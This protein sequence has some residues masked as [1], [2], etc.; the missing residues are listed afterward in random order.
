MKNK[1]YC[2]LFFVFLFNQAAFAQVDNTRFKERKN[3][4]K[5]NLIP[6][7][8]FNTAQLSYERTIKPQLTIGGSINGS[9]SKESPSF[10][11]LGDLSGLSFAGDEL[12]SFAI[13]PQV[14]WYPKL[15]DR[16]TPHGF[17]LGG[18]LRY[19]ILDYKTDVAY[20]DLATTTEDFKWD[21][22]L[23]SFAVGME[24]GYQIK[25][26]NNWLFD[27]SFFGPRI[28]FH[29][30][31]S[32]TN[33]ILDN[34]ILSALSKELNNVIG[35]DFFDADATVTNEAEKEKFVLPGF[36]YAIS[37]GYNF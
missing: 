15:S 18:L 30:L 24:L 37:V 10:I 1:F 11:N 26:K 32:E 29:T 22:A 12:S 25:F 7:L 14:K 3:Q 8:A 4:I 6:L 5:L 34:E 19:Q 35:G 21:V 23:N 33:E 2:F 31:I 13:M 27:F 36:R 16:S 28:V 20:E 17:Y 9:F